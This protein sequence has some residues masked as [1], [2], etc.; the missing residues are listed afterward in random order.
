MARIASR[1]HLPSRIPFARPAPEGRSLEGSADGDEIPWD[2]TAEKAR[3]IVGK[4]EISVI[5][6]VARDLGLT[7][8]SNRPRSGWQLICVI[9]PLNARVLRRCPR[10][11]ARHGLHLPC[12]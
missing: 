2:R 9:L 10:C 1:R 5:Q 12:L 8:R 11:A 6:S 3:R 4:I 7:P